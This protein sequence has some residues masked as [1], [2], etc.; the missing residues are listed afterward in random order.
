MERYVRKV[1]TD[2]HAP[3]EV[4]NREIDNRFAVGYVVVKMPTGGTTGLTV[5]QAMDFAA[6]LLEAIKH[7]EE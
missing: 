2:Y 7:V 3:I 5:S 4:G 1:K 6:A